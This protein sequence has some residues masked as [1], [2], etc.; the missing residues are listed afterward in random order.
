MA[1][2][3]ATANSNG[4][5][6][7]VSPL[8]SVLSNW[9]G[10]FVSATLSLV[11][12]PILIHGLGDLYYGMWVLIATLLDSYGLLDFGV[13]NA[14]FRFVA[15]YKG[16]NQRREL[17]ATLA[18]GFIIALTTAAIVFLL[19]VLS[20]AFLPGFFNVEGSSRHIFRWL[21]AMLGTGVAF[22]FPAQFLGTYL[23]ACRRFDLFNFTVIL[24]GLLRAGLI[25]LALRLHY[26]V[27]AVGAITFGATVLSFLLNL[28]LVHRSDPEVSLRPSLAERMRVKELLSF[29]VYAF[30]G[31]IGD[32]LRFFVDNIVIGR[33]LAIALITPFNIAGRL[34]VLM[35]QLLLS[36]AS[37]LSGVMSELQ[38]KGNEEDLRSY[39]L[40]AT[41]LTSILSFYV[42]L[43]LLVNG[44]HIITL[45]VGHGYP[46]SYLLL[47]VLIVGYSITLAQHPSVDL[48]MAKH[49]HQPRGWWTLAEGVANLILSV[50]L[51]RRYGLIGIALGTT[52]PML[53][54]QIFVQPWYTLRASGISPRRYLREAML[55]PFIAAAIFLAVCWLLRSTQ[56][57]VSFPR[58]FLSVAWQSVVFG[59]LA[60]VF[61]M[62]AEERGRLL[63][64]MQKLKSIV[65]GSRA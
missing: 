8:R 57:V 42:G 7:Q 60:Y 2:T 29:S 38:G 35:R 22:A 21:V 33:V 1:D 18:S 47:V 31:N 65:F 19:T 4:A 63:A 16:A 36:L 10:L 58:L 6:A 25:I 52:I 55:G 32:H 50:I 59:A 28:Y 30:L 26:G 15:V 51:A 23:C 9:I 64:G 27:I 44:R 3:Q 37:P 49:S 53:V 43:I 48:L 5:Q 40:H 56:T 34:M 17:N 46:E 54:V 45:W 20:V 39:F 11:M 13:R 24:S 61:A 14:L 12:T 62:K 41:R